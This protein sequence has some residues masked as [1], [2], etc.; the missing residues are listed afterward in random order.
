MR[1]SVS[2]TIMH[3]VMV[4]E[5]RSNY[6]YRNDDGINYRYT[7]ACNRTKKTE[8]RGSEQ[9]V[10]HDRNRPVLANECKAMIAIK[11]AALV[12]RWIVTKVILEHNLSLTPETSFLHPS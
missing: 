4:L 9:S 12:N 10:V 11:D 2:T 8:R 5:R 6:R 1:R 3:V 7:F